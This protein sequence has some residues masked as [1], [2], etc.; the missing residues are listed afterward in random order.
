MKE[1]KFATIKARNREIIIAKTVLKREASPYLHPLTYIA[2]AK[3]AVQSGSDI[4]SLEPI[5]LQSGTLVEYF[6]DKGLYSFPWGWDVIEV[7]RQIHELKA[8]IRIGGFE[9][10]PIPKAFVHN[11][12]ACNKKLYNAISEYNRVKSL[13]CFEEVECNCKVEWQENILC[14]GG[15]TIQRLEERVELMLA[16]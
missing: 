13:S 7:V 10:Y 14:E 11:C 3:M 15:E 1:E 5:S 4:I 9:F 12:V 8:L 16:S 2:T 6:Y